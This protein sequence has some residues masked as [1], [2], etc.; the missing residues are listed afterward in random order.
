MSAKSLRIIGAFFLY[1]FLLSLVFYFST[2]VLSKLILPFFKFTVERVS[3]DYHVMNSYYESDPERLTFEVSV[4]RMHSMPAT[5]KQYKS[6]SL[7]ESLR[8]EIIGIHFLIAF[9]LSL[10]WPGVSP[11]ERIH[12]FLV[13][14]PML[15]VLTSFDTAFT[16]SG[17]IEGYYLAFVSGTPISANH[18]SA[19]P[20]FVDHLFMK[21]G[22]YVA[23][24]GIFFIALHLTENKTD[25][26]S[27]EIGRNDAC[28]CG[29]GKK[30]KKCCMKE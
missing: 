14:V 21:G 9:S 1:Y 6:F 16:L 3:T 7:K 19:E 20:R 18:Y 12:L 23:S 13:L 5:G 2:P 27:G 25:L 15:I 4:N 10:I 11:R 17:R 29:S 8:A 22:R 26:R 24:L 30:Y 28:P